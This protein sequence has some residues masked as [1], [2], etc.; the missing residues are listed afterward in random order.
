M[1]GW[2]LILGGFRLLQYLQNEI[3]ICICCLHG[4]FLD[5]ETH[6]DTAGLRFEIYLST[7]VPISVC[8]SANYVFVTQFQ[9]FNRV[10]MSSWSLKNHRNE[11]ITMRYLLPE[12]P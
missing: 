11:A 4:V 12:F 5:I 10:F 3:S 9:V 7:A 6:V 8:A 2:N 1:S